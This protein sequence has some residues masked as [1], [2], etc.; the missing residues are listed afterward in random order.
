MKEPAVSADP[1]QVLA[2]ETDCHIFSGC[3]F[4]GPGLHSFLFEPIFGD[5][6][7]NI[8][9]NKTMLLALLGTVIIVGFFWA[10]F[11]K[12]KVVP[13]KLQMVAEA[14]YDFVRRG[15]VY[16]TLGKREGEKYVPLM[17]SIFFFVWMMNLWS[18]IPLA[19]FPVTS[20]IAYPAGLAA[21]VYV[22]WMSI[23]FKRHGFVGGFKNL[24]G[25]DKS[26]GPVL[27]LVMVIE[28]FSNV[29]VRPFTHAVRLFANMFAGHTLLLLFTIASWYL[30]NGIGIAYAGVSFV[31]VIVMTAFELFIQAVQA[32]VF[33][34]L[35]CS[36]I[37]G[38]V[39]EHH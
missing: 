30:L 23:T 3:G 34:L 31:M 2:F 20:I 38:A 39:A 1:T 12:P 26:L 15:I 16:E 7:S 6:D 33:V 11:R 25:Y 36:F 4:P 5:A 18:I 29:L 17:V 14:G 35:A 22:L 8:Y 10:A 27:P 19:Q 24:T 13:G 28:F 32:Y 9:F 21:I 37:Q